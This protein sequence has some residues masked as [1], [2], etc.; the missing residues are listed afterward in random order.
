MVLSHF[1]VAAVLSSDAPQTMASLKTRAYSLCFNWQV[2]PLA[3]LA[4]KTS[5]LGVIFLKLRGLD[6]RVHKTKAMI[7]FVEW[8]ADCGMR[9]EIT[10]L[11]PSS[12]VMK[13]GPSSCRAWQK[14]SVES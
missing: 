3:D 2:R 12:K 8:C 11:G 10:R 1:S 4:E 13:L 7:V 9:A 6:R 14:D 5:L